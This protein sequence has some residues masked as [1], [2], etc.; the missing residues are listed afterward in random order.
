MTQNWHAWLPW[1]AWLFLAGAALAGALGWELR[2]RSRR[3]GQALQSAEAWYRAVVESSDDAIIGKDL[4][5]TILS[6]NPAAQRLFGYTAAEALGQP[7]TMLFPPG[8]EHEE[9]VL[10]PRIRCGEHISHHEAERVCREGRT[11]A[12]SLSI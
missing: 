4:R 11:V 1:L 7:I 6:W 12:V 3:A 5:G 2:R 8:T 9:T 10:L